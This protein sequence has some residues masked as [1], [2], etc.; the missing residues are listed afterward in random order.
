MLLLT[1]APAVGP[2]LP[3]ILLLDYL[4][5]LISS[6]SA[7]HF[8]FSSSTINLKHQSKRSS[9]TLNQQTNNFHNTTTMDTIKSTANY[10]SGTISSC[11][12]HSPDT[13]H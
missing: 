8:L 2:S 10:V 4:K 7:H 5:T 11:P 6:T 12:N 1:V 13:I 3:L 9:L